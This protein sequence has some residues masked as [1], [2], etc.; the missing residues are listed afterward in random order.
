[1]TNAQTLSSSTPVPAAVSA[2]DVLVQLAAQVGGPASP[3]PDWIKIAP[4]GRVTDRNGATHVFDPEALAARFAADDTKIPLDFDHS[5]VL[6]GAKGQRSD[7]VGWIEEMEARADGLYGRVDWLDTGKAALAARTH[8]YISPSFPRDTAGNAGWIHSVALVTAPALS[9]MPALAHADL[10]LKPDTE[11]TMSHYAA[12]AATLGLGSDATET[13]V[14]AAV[15]KLKDGDKVDKAVHD[16][17][18][19][20]LA[21]TTKQLQTLQAAGRKASVDAVLEQA[22]KEKRIVPAQRETYEALCASDE[23]LEHVKA[24]LAA[25]PAN[26][27]ASGLDGKKPDPG[28]GGE[29]AEIDPV[30]LAAKANEYLSAQHAAGNPITYLS[31]FNHV[32]AELEKEASH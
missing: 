15:Q 6:L 22:L 5:T 21:S 2:G 14:L 29:P 19:A 11:H 3:A 16:Q 31:A 25:T 8:R 24:L 28:T 10:S 20:N 32:E 18:L 4:R 17:T 30:V 13:A 9:K 7:A 12:L 27:T 26:L 23:G 1:M